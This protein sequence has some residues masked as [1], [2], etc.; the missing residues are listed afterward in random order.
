MTSSRGSL[1]ASSLG[2]SSPSLTDLYLDPPELGDPDLRQKLDTLLQD[3]V[4]GGYRPSSSIPTIHENEV[5]GAAG[6]GGGGAQRL[7]ALR[8]SETPRSSGSLSPRSSLSSLSPPCSPLVADSSF[9]SGD[10]FLGLAG[11]SLDTELQSRLTELALGTDDEDASRQHPGGPKR[12][13]AA[14]GA[15]TSKGRAQIATFSLNNVTW[16]LSYVCPGDLLHCLDF[17]Q[18]LFVS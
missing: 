14:G 1:A 17:Y 4:A 15:E 16:L 12:D 6:G 10:A 18:H 3:S 11:T 7:Q 9:L 2:S 5:V 13:V 8:L